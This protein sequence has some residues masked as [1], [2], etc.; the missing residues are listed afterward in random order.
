M[1]DESEAAMSGLYW[2]RFELRLSL[3]EWV[4]RDFG[5]FSMNYLR[6]LN[7]NRWKV[8]AQNS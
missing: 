5:R 6:L 2:N 4:W 7:V 8:F 3:K 1:P